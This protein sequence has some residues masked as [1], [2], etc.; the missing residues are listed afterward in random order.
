MIEG[1]LHIELS[2][3]LDGGYMVLGVKNLDVGIADDVAGGDFA[4]GSRFNEN[5]F[6]R[7]GVELCDDA[8]DVQDDL[9]H[10][11]FHAGDG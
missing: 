4:A 10:I 3:F 1:D 2:A 5:R 7:L 8:L 9:G 11:L 6:R